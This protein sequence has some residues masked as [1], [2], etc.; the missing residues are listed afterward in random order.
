MQ[1]LRSR[2]FA[3]LLATLSVPCAVAQAGAGPVNLKVLPKDISLQDLSMRMAALQRDLGVACAFCHD[4]DPDTKK[5]NY[6]SDDNPRKETA[7][8]MMRMTNDINDKYLGMLGD[9]QDAPPIRCGNCHL[10]QMHPP[11]FQ[12][13]AR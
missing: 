8:A 9:R 3:G 6:A 2:L 13:A 12:P 5:I 1:V 10:G 7:R 4:E 11:A